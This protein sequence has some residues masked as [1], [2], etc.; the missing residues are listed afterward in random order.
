M[1]FRAKSTGKE[2]DTGKNSAAAASI[3]FVT[4]CRQEKKS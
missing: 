2:G 1:K 4:S 3:K